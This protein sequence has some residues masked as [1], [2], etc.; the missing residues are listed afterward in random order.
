MLIHNTRSTAPY[1][2][3]RSPGWPTSSAPLLGDPGLDKHTPLVE[4]KQPHPH[5]Q[6]Q[7]P[8]PQPQQR[9]RLFHRLFLRL[10]LWVVLLY[11]AVV[12]VNGSHHHHPHPHHHRHAHQPQPHYPLCGTKQGL[13]VTN[14]NLTLTQPYPNIQGL[15]CS[16][17]YDAC[18]TVIDTSYVLTPYMY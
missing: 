9:R 16:T 1:P 13:Q 3:I 5:P 12:A 2:S 10:L 17:T 7:S 8:L 6:P 11:A 4:H 15:Y 18:I 14:P